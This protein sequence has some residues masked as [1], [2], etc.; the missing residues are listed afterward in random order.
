MQREGLSS[1]R[2]AGPPRRPAGVRFLAW[3][4]ANLFPNWF[5]ALASLLLVAGLLTILPAL[6][7]WA[8]THAQFAPDNAACR[9]LEGRGACWG[10]IA[11]KY[12]IILFGRYPHDQQWRPL[13]ATGLLLAMLV[14]SCTRPLWG[15]WLAPAWALVLAVFFGLM[16]GGAF[17]LPAVATSY[18]GGLPLTM[19]LATFGVATAFPLAIL[20]ALGR[21]SSLPAIRA[22][23]IGYV[24]MVR[25]V[26][27]IS[28]LFMASFLFPLFMPRG[29]NIDVLARVLAGI[30]LFAAAYL[31]EVVRA[32]LQAV[33]RGQRDAAAAL[34]LG[35]WQMQA[36]IVLPQA[37]RM[38]VPSIMNSFIST[39]KDTSLVVIVS[40]YELT[41]SLTLAL[42][43]DAEWRRFYLEGYLFIGAI[44]WVFCY[45]MSCYS[46][47]IEQRLHRGTRRA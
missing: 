16:G 29:F 47:W 10:V 22:L 3:L 13:A 44:Y 41:G 31:A 9:A 1:A 15:K 2:L 17:G 45:A 4:R 42:A 36:G 5:S 38:V 19:M 28:V 24:E 21:Q 11:E 27:L 8:W 20:I 26:P 43:G 30:A 25:G 12:R 7:Q 33:P 23:C 37:L 40:L 39:F 32:G 18:W 46:R 35:Y 6:F 14:V 34:G